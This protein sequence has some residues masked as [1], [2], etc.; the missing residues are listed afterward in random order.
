MEKDLLLSLVTAFIA[1]L[2]ALVTPF[3]QRWKR[4]ED[5]HYLEEAEAISK[6]LEHA[7]AAQRGK[8]LELA[9]ERIPPGL[10]PTQLTELLDGLAHRISALPVPPVEERV[11]VEGLISG[12]HEQ[13]LSQAKAQFWFSVVAATIGFAWILYGGSQISPEKLATTSHIL[14]GVVMNAVA[15]LFFRQSSETRR[16]ATDLYDRLRRDKQVA[17]SVALV[18]SIEDVLVRS[19]VRAQI[20]L[21]MSGLQPAPIELS[22]FLSA[23][24]GASSDPPHSGATV[25]AS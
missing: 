13:A 18:S 25:A 10:S 14:P 22:S 12:Y 11:A 24:R 8:A 3:I 4:A 2:A 19:A 15:F 7:K 21:H 1:F 9:A 17:E 5:R 16:R 6:A 20:A 23:Q